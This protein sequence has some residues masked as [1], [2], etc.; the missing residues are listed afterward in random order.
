MNQEE[1]EDMARFILDIKEERGV[2]VMMIEH[3][4]GVVMDICDRVT[5]LNFGVKI[6]EGGPG[7]IREDPEVVKA[8]LGKAG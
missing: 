2:T 6:A 4:M 3:H 8:Y 1:T 5:V 7:D